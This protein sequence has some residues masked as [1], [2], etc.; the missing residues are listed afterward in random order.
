MKFH[1]LCPHPDPLPTA[2]RRPERG[3]FVSVFKE[4]VRYFGSWDDPK[5]VLKKYLQQKDDLLAGREPIDE[6]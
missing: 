4:K 3:G 2:A 1:N 6:V 5:A